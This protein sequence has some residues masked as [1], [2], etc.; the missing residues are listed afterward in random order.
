M[1]LLNAVQDNEALIKGMQEKV[2][3]MQDSQISFLNNVLSNIG[4]QLGIVLTLFTLIFAGVGWMINRS[5]ENAQRKM[6][7]AEIIINQAE[8]AMNKFSKEKAE[9]EESRQQLENY[10]KETEE[11]RKETERRFTELTE[12]VNS[13][14]IEKL[15]ESMKI[16]NIRHQMTNITENTKRIVNSGYNE[17]QLIKDIGDLSE[18]GDLER[19]FNDF[20][21]EFELLSREILEPILNFQEAEKLIARCVISEESARLIVAKLHIFATRLMGNR[22]SGK[23]QKSP[24]QP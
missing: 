4:W 17:M 10:R 9:L 24:V 5:N 2:I 12:L 22:Y 18:Y 16:L 1:L 23:Q 15:K 14:E 7:N 21:A 19:E 8:I 6:E 20:R 13:K 11:Y 3:S